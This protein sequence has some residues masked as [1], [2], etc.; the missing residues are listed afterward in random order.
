[1]TILP[2]KTAQYYPVLLFSICLL[3]AF[4][5]SSH[6]NNPARKPNFIFILTDDQGWTSTSQLMDDYVV[7]SKS[8]YFET[9]Q[10]ERLAKNGMR[11]TNGYAPCALCCPTRR[12]IQFGQTPARQGD[13][14]FKQNYHPDFKRITT[15]PQ[16]LKSISPE[17]RAAHFGKWDLRAEIFPEDLGYDESDGDTGNNNGDMNSSK[18]TKWTDLFLNNDPKRIE[19]ITKRALN[20]MTRQA[21]SGH[22]F[23]LQVSHYATH[24]D[25][26]TKEKTYEKYMNKAKGEVHKNAGYAGMLEDLDAGIGAI[27]DKIDELGINNNTYIILMADNGGVEFITPVKNKFDHPSTFL[28]K[29][30]NYPLRGGKWTLYEGGIRVPFIVSGPGIKAGSQS[31]VPVAG[32]DIM[33]TLSDIAGNTNELPPNLDG[34]SFKPMLIAAKE[35]QFNMRNRALVFHYFGKEHSSIHVN[36]YKLIKFWKTNKIELYDLKHDLGELNDISQENKS[37]ANELEKMLMDYLVSVKAEVL[38]TP[39]N[40]GKKEPENDTED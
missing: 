15:I 4:V 1:M 17:Y 8:D 16:L 11:F 27:L 36:D 30:R 25:F 32:W 19:S 29:S 2:K 12:S 35:N 22:P 9:P 26:Q 31:D 20:F 6:K 18:Q 10:I 40:I 3:T 34:K 14:D 13:A 23:Y 33:P 7:N 39:K 37:K 5:F 38:Y 24:V 21:K 28:Q